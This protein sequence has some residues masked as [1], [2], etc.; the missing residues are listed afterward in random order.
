MNAT[1]VGAGL[2]G[3][4]A[5]ICLARKGYQ[6]EVLERAEGIGGVSLQFEE[7]YKQQYVFGDMT[8]FHVEQLSNY[9]NIDL[10]SRHPEDDDTCFYRALPFAR[11]YSYGKKYDMEFPA[12]VHMKLIERGPRESSLDS[13]L[14]RTALKH[15]VRF[16]FGAPIE[17]EKDFGAL[18]ERTILSTGMFIGTYKVL[19]IPFE[20]VFGYF[21]NRKMDEYEGPELVAHFDKYTRDFGLFAVINGIGGATLFQ[22]K[23]PLSDQSVQWYRR[24]LEEREGITFSSWHP[25]EARMATP[26]G[27]VSNPRLFHG[28]FIL[29]GT[30]S[31]MQDP[32]GAFGVHGALVSG[33][34]AAMA[35]DDKEEALREFK[36][37]NKRWYL[38]Y[39][40]KTIMDSGHP[41]V[42]HCL[43]RPV[44]GLSAYYDLRYLFR[45]L[46]AVPG[47]MEVDKGSEG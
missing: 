9:L 11:F 44:L 30:L 43:L 17:S 16:Q 46:A 42:P 38:C 34:I 6:V 36:R 39:A 8:P 23:I 15:G 40:L 29:S 35:I 19:N 5:A 24:D 13:Y 2:S 20:P 28:R 12:K 22:R 47:W 33:K 18:P 31:G 41:H 25:S 37:M 7:Q 26:T 32:I 4:V 1:I 14:Y 45:Y 3:M 27:S 21:A 10:S